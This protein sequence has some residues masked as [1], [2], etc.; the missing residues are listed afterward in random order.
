MAQKSVKSNAVSKATQA[1]PISL[2]LPV[3]TRIGN[4][5][6]AMLEKGITERFTTILLVPSNEKDVSKGVPVLTHKPDT[7]DANSQISTWNSELG[8]ILRLTQAMVNGWTASSGLSGDGSCVYVLENSD[9]AVKAV[10]N[11]LKYDIYLKPN[12]RSGA[13]QYR[14][15]VPKMLAMLKDRG[16]V[17]ADCVKAYG[18]AAGKKRTK[19]AEDAP[20]VI[21]QL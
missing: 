12:G 15:P 21:A 19:K 3:V 2:Q 6:D 13:G 8:H 5:V 17:I 9:K 11:F 20:Q 16:Q 18:I 10:P 4:D 1:Q 14:M 7:K